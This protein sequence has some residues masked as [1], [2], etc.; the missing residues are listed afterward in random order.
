[1]VA[2]AVKQI[3]YDTQSKLLIRVMVVTFLCYFFNTGWI[4][5]LVNADLSEQ[6]LLGLL[7]HS[8]KSADFDF[9]FY[10]TTAATLTGTMLLNTVMP[11]IMFLVHWSMRFALRFYDRHFVCRHKKTSETRKTAI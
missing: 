2:W 1:V 11:V 7:I 3:G 6:P 8:G 4:I 5:I 10:K 9:S